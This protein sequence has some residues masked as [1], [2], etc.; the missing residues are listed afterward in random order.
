MAKPSPEPA[1]SR[2]ERQIMD[3]V[4]AAEKATAA[5][6]QKQL[7]DDLSYSTV[8]TL[9]RILE[10]KGYLRH[11]EEGLRYV[12]SPAIPREAAR[13]SAL[14]RILRTFFDG[15]AQQAVAALLETSHA[16]ADAVMR[17]SFDM[18]TKDSRRKILAE[19][20][21]LNKQLSFTLGE[22]PAS[23]GETLEL[24]P[25]SAA[26]DRDIFAARTEEIK[27]AGDGRGGPAG[28]LE[29]EISAALRR[30]DDEEAA[31]FVAVDSG[32]KVGMVFGELVHGEV[33]LRIWIHP[34]HR[35]KGY[36]TAAL[37]Y[38]ALD[39]PMLIAPVLPFVSAMWVVAVI[40][41]IL[42]P[43]LHRGIHDRLADTIAA[44]LAGETVPPLVSVPVGVVT[45][46]S[47]AAESGATP[48]PQAPG[49]S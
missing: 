3:V 40:V 18:L 34:E 8:R 49:H 28:R 37:R 21:D 25:F 33:D 6:I 5:E 7:P 23:S 30:V 43:P 27:T 17:M 32:Q 46:E 36:G 16:A 4:Y 41:T 13:K 26:E 11:G 44:H 38:A 14:Q 48:A 29:D 1:L 10:S 39:G 20:E 2:R 22:R 19:L 42:R 15:S 35:K 45:P 9:L 31:W 24:R 12:Y 47:L